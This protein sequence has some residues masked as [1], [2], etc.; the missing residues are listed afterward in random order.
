MPNIL[1][2]RIRDAM[3]GGG[4]LELELDQALNGRGPGPQQVYLH[5]LGASIG[6]DLEENDGEAA[7]ILWL[8][9]RQGS[10]TVLQPYSIQR[11]AP[12]TLFLTYYLSGCKIFAIQG[13]PVWHI[14][15]PVDVGEFWPEIQ[16]SEWVEDHWPAGG[17]Q[18]VAYLHR[19]GQNALLWDLSAQLQ[20]GAP[21]TYGHGNLGQALVGGVV[22]NGQLDLYVKSSPWAALAYGLQKLRK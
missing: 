2:D 7:A 20:G 12:D 6:I 3:T 5:D 4:D 17:A 15:A 11:A 18:D 13:G 10:L 8:P 14:D 16:G 21:T 22:N 19:A 9:W 1:Q